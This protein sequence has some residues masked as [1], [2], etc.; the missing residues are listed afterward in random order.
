VLRRRRTI[1]LT[2]AG[3]L[4]LFA[5]SLGFAGAADNSVPGQFDPY[6]H[7]TSGELAD[8]VN[9]IFRGTMEQ[10]AAAVPRVLG[11]QS[12]QGSEMVFYD[13]GAHFA[14]GPQ[15]GFDIG[16][17]SRYHIRLEAVQDDD[18]QTYV[19][20]G[21]HRDDSVACGH[22]GR[23][24]DR[25]RDLVA[26]AFTDAGYPVTTLHLGNSDPGRQCDGSFTFGD[27]TAAMIDLTG[28][29]AEG[30]SRTHIHLPFGI[31]IALPRFHFL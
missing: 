5:A 12:V 24:F 29:H 18:G 25:M 4:L 27:G 15:F 3:L 31:D 30:Q 7:R 21:V 10:A 17:G 19:L 23:A 16:G 1:A 26:S 11:W 22:V 20:S 8:P 28:G 6:L 14:T 13:H 2:A 9:L